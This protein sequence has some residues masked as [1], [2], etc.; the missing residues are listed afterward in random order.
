MFHYKHLLPA[1][2]AV[3][4]FGG[5]AACSDDDRPAAEGHD[6]VL[7]WH[8]EFNQPTQ[9]GKPDSTKWSFETGPNPS[10]NEL[11]YYTDRP[12]NIGFTTYGGESCL[13]ITALKENYKGYAYTSARIN[14]KG[15]F[16]Q[17]YGRFEARIWLTYAPGIWP[18]WWLLGNN[19]DKV[20]WPQCGEIDIMENKGWQPNIVSSALHFPGRFSGNP[21]GA[22]YG[23]TNARFDTGFHLYAVEWDENY[24]DFYVDNILYNRVDAHA[25]HGGTWVFDHPFFLLLNV[26]VG[27]DFVGYPIDTTRFPQNLYVDYVR[28]YKDRRNLKPG[29]LDSEGNI[30]DW[31]ETGGSTVNPD[32]APKDAGK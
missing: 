2:M 31:E 30:R 21:V 8:D 6:W 11:Q 3:L 19:Y 23:M 15:H 10:N 29:D 14:T 28:V 13:R 26:A 17:T 12:E 22:S 9:N 24:I 25:N 16:A 4:T 32:A 1:V 27:G 5:L 20:G 18:A 7:V